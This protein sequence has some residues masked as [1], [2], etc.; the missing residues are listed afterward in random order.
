MIRWRHLHF[1]CCVGSLIF[2]VDLGLL[3]VVRF[4]LCIVCWVWLCFWVFLQRFCILFQVVAT[5][6]L[7]FRFWVFVGVLESFFLLVSFFP[8]HF[9]WW[10]VV[11]LI[12]ACLLLTWVLWWLVCFLRFF[13][14]KSLILASVHSKAVSFVRCFLIFRVRFAMLLFFLQKRFSTSSKLL[15][16]WLLTQ[17]V[18]FD[19]CVLRFQFDFQVFLFVVVTLNKDFKG[20][21]ASKITTFT[22]TRVSASNHAVSE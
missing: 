7:N 5:K 22:A 12:F 20:L 6:N 2:W 19:R 11:V 3:W 16:R 1:V 15:R 9:V 18:Q 14:L 10:E 17:W 13:W 21:P 4:F 8:F